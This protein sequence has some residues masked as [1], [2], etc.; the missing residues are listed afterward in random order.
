LVSIVVSERRLTCPKAAALGQRYGAEVG[1]P[2]SSKQFLFGAAVCSAFRH[3]RAPSP[4]L[5]AGGR[6]NR[7]EFENGSGESRRA[8]SMP[9]V[10]WSW[11]RGLPSRAQQ[12]GTSRGNADSW[13]DKRANQL[14]SPY[15]PRSI[16]G[17]ANPIM[18]ILGNLQMRSRPPMEDF[19]VF[20]LRTP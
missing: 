20:G 10:S 12:A 14:A 16:C 5:R 2:A 3:R 4:E 6:C 13:A 7:C 17:V 19:S 1:P 9:I 11:Q 8:G 15:A 18:T